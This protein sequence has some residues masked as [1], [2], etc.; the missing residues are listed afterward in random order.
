MSPAEHD[1]VPRHTLEEREEDLVPDRDHGDRE[2][3]VCV[4][5]AGEVTLFEPEVGDRGE[6]LA[7]RT[8]SDD[9]AGDGGFTC[10][11]G[12]GSRT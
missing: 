9:L 8:R 7:P 10:G 3:S 2:G 1:Q 6:R 5:D 12:Q 11:G 4:L